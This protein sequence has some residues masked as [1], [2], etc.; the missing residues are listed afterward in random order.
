MTEARRVVR[1][2]KRRAGKNGGEKQVDK[3]EEC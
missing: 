2:A 1:V 3:E